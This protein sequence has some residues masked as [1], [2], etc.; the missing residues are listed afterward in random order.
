VLLLEAGQDTPPGAVPADIEDTYPRSYSNPNY[1]WPD[2]RVHFKPVSSGKPAV[3][4]EQ[5]RVMGGGSSVQGMVALRGLAADYYGWAAAG[6]EGW[7]WASVLP[8][9]RR[10]ENDWD[11]DGELHGKDG[12]VVIRRYDPKDWPPFS[13]A[14]QQAAVNQ[15]YPIIAD[16]NGEFG[17]GY[18]SLPM[19]KTM[20]K[21][22]SSASGYLDEETRRRPN[23][24]ISSHTTVEKIIFEGNR[25][26]GVT[27]VKDGTLVSFK[28]RH[29]VL[30]AGAIHTPAIL[31]R[32]GVGDPERISSLG[33]PVVAASPGVG[34]N[35]QNHVFLYLA[36]H[37]KKDA[38]QTGS[39]NPF[40]SCN[41]FRFSSGLPDLTNDMVMLILNR[42]SWHRLG[43]SIA[44]LGVAL[45]S[46]YSRGR[47][48]LSSP[49]PGVE[50][51]VE[52]NLLQ[53]PRD[54]KRMVDGMAFALKLMSDPAVRAI[55]QQVFAVAYSERARKLGNPTRSNALTAAL[56]AAIFDGPAFLGD[57]LLR[58]AIAPNQPDETGMDEAFMTRMVEDQAVG[59][60][61]VVGTCRMGRADDPQ[62]VLNARCQVRGV[63]GLSVA[64]A[65]VM[66]RIPRANTYLASVM[67]AE[68]CSDLLLEER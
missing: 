2:L 54:K 59:M 21:R 29:V 50:P 10:L 40:R 36:A 61:H 43:E 24:Q 5:A 34:E 53:D 14:V 7:D 49:A 66:P 32:S 64:D 48:T 18:G 1:M 58:H 8:Y 38:R 52:F 65:S 6:A 12:P 26:V 31:M 60:F 22:V 17:D 9:F 51:Q 19:C 13:N 62:A 44:A 63:E 67:I 33:I 41:Y 11:F 57:L 20:E 23:L 35:L 25:A 55:R 16:M 30:S 3:R 27:A 37:L 42:T 45:Y 46:P 47:V 68:K 56:L 4:F 28:A 15:G 39:N